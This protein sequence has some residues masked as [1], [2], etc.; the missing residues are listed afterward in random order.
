MALIRKS[1]PT[2]VARQE[3]PRIR[4]PYAMGALV[5]GLLHFG[6]L[7][8]FAS[9]GIW[10]LAGIQVVS[11]ACFAGAYL[12]LRR[13][14]PGLGL[15]VATT[16]IVVHQ[17][18]GTHL[19]GWDAGFAYLLLA[20][21]PVVMLYPDA[22][23]WVRFGTPVLLIVLFLGLFTLYVG[24]PA[25]IALDDMLLLSMNMANQIGAFVILWL[26]MF[27]YQRGAELSEGALNIARERSDRLLHNILPEEIVER[28]RRQPGVV[29]DAFEGT[30]I[31]FADLV[32]FT[33]LAQEKT[34]EDLVVLLDAIVGAFD[35]LTEER[36]LEKIKTIGD[37]YMVASGVPKA[38]PD[39]AAAMADLALAMRVR[40]D[41]VAERAGGSL[42]MRIG[43]HSGPVV[44]GVIGKS[45]FAY[46]LWGDTVNTAARMESHGEPGKIHV[47]EAT[48]RALGEGWEVEERGVIEVKGKGSMRTYWLIG[49][50]QSAPTDPAAAT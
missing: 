12:S 46:D 40:F 36:G 44:A 48:V 24:V 25:P 15:A 11:I 30:S 13:G 2:L 47:T 27:F 35:E 49:R 26:L 5:G 7:V 43:V 33:L 34:P 32:G 42:R 23:R 16:E 18:I 20:V 37:A 22:P 19:L 10:L 9:L 39:H 6:F 3:S 28:L 17:M 29:A 38:R 31:L 14:R 45:K 8:F 50:A 21:A 4:V 1:V 41:E